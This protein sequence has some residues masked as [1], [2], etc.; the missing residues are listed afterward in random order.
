MIMESEIRDKLIAFLRDEIP[1]SAFEDWLVS[2]SWNMHLD[3][4]Q[5][6]QE[7]VSAIELELAEY[8][9]G[10]LKYSELRNNLLHLLDNMFISVQRVSPVRLPS[11]ASNA[12]QL[13]ASVVR[14]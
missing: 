12:F 2:K 4:A 1:L 3:S 7:L 8:S 14:L 5:E 6:A 9:S 10:H 13:P 11:F